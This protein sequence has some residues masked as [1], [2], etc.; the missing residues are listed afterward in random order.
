VAPEALGL[1]VLSEIR[2]RYSC[3]AGLSDHSGT[4]FPSLAAVALGARVVEVHVTLSR[5]MFGPDV[6]ASVTTAELRSLVDGVRM[7]G[8]ALEHPVDKDVAAAGMEDMRRLFTRSLVTTRPIAAG[9]ALADE[10][11]VARKPGSGIPAGERA[12]VLGRRLRA[13]VPADHLLAEED[14]V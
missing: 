13:S 12:R 14:L 11:L 1:N 8:K 4:I 5:E 3:A 6:Q 7:I 10:D 9:E 2:R